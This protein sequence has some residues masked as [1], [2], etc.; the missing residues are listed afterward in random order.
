MFTFNPFIP[1][2]SPQKNQGRQPKA[3]QGS[4]APR[5]AAPALRCTARRWGL[6]A[7]RGQTWA[8]T[9]RKKG[10][11]PWD[12]GT[13]VPAYPKIPIPVPKISKSMGTSTKYHNVFF[14]VTKKLC[15]P[16]L[17]TVEISVYEHQVQ[18]FGCHSNLDE[19]KT[20]RVQCLNSFAEVHILGTQRSQLSHP[21]ATTLTDWQTTSLAASVLLMQK[22]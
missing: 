10:R 3:T 4:T 17:N 21:D 22:I 13:K 14:I 18:L 19:K 5:S 6:E 1:S 9:N 11:N 8:A 12:V 7:Q 15:P 16:R 2:W 20:G